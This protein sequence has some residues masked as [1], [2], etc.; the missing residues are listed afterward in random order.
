VTKEDLNDVGGSRTLRNCSLPPLKRH[1]AIDYAWLFWAVN[2]RL[3]TA[4][5]LKRL[6]VPIWD[7]ANVG[8]SDSDLSRPI[9]EALA[10]C[11]KDS[12]SVGSPND[13]ACWA[14]ARHHDYLENPFSA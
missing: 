12:F 11:R 14:A 4:A 1:L 8:D 10:A 13:L 3:P 5:K 9:K 7:I 6:I 2:G